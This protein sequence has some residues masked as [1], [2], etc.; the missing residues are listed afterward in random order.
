MKRYLKVCVLALA[1]LVTLS[2]GAAAQQRP[3]T[4]RVGNS[5]SNEPVIGATVAVVG[6]AI[7]A[8]TDARGE[9]TLAAPAGPV[10]LSVRAIGYKRRT[11]A[12]S[13]DQASVAIQVEADIF[14]LEAVVVTGQATAVEQK[15]LPQA[16]SVVTAQQ[17]EAVP[18]PTIESTLQGKIPG[19]LIQSNS[20][21]PG[22][23]AQI[24]LRG[25]STINGGVDPV[26][27]VDG[28]VVSNAAIGNN[29]NAITAAAAGG[30]ASNQ[31]NP[32]NRIADLNPAD[33]ERVEVLKGAS[34]AAIY[35]GAA[36]NGVL[37]ITTKRGAA[38][39]PR[40]HLT[41]RFGQYRVS[42][43]MKSRVFTDSADAAT[44]VGDSLAGV[45]CNLPGGA[46]P[47]Y[48][49]IGPLWKGHPLSW[50]TLASVTGG[51]DQTRYYISGLLKSDG[52]IAPGTGYDK[53]SIRANLDQTFGS[54]WL[55]SFSTSVIH[56]LA[57]RGISNNDNTGTSPYLVFP[58]TPGFVDLQSQNGVFPDNPF[59]RSN[60][61]QTYANL[62]NDE[63][64]WRALGAATLRFD[65]FNNE[66]QNLRFLVTGGLDHFIQE[67][68]IYSPP[69]LEFEPNDGQP[70]TVVLGKTSNVNLN[71]L[72]N[73]VHTYRTTGGMRATTALG[74][75]YVDRN[76]NFT[77]LVGRNLPPGQQNIDQAT[78]V[79]I[80]QT[81][82][83]TQDLGLFVQEELLTA[84][85]RLM[86]TFGVRADRSSRNGDVNKYYYY[87]KIAGSYRLTNLGGNSANEVKLR[88]AYGQT[89]NPPQFGN[90][91]TPN[92][93]G[94]IGGIFGSSAGAIAGD[95]G[96]KPERQAEIEA[97]LDATLAGGRLTVSLTGFNKS[98]TDLLL[99]Q[100]L[101]PSTGRTQRVFNGGELRNRGVEASAAY[102]VTQRADVSWIVKGTFFANRS[103]VVSLPVPAFQV[104]GFGTS[105]GAFEIRE[106]HSVT[107]IVG[108]PIDSLGLPTIVGDANPDFQMAFG[109][110]LEYHRWSVGFLFDWKKG[111]DVINLTE[112]LFDLFGNSI[113][114]TGAAQG[115]LN[116]FFAGRTQPYVQDASYLKLRE[117]AVSY[118]LPASATATLFGSVV[119]DARVTFAG[120]NL[121]RF[122]PFRGMDPEVS[123]FGNQAVARNIDVAPF[124]PSRSFFVAI[125][126][127][128]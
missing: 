85:E 48:D 31:D 93:T 63:D 111:G 109:S 16:V 128:F 1:W 99:A 84:D 35:G 119:R 28:L 71:L 36:S 9:F 26:L 53:Q 52:G 32:V 25:V 24:N 49:N 126:L 56:S 10:S 39:A 114:Q 74:V 76:F 22:G 33:I 92:A 4:G 89:G 62:R 105:L 23:G 120:R 57:A 91:F 110:D 101:A 72:T 44:F 5:V 116:D 100:T 38:G 68:D 60:P 43:Y 65:A 37:I 81:L 47:N 118:H 75:Q 19:A 59:E 67:N 108:T 55:L 54:K 61:L 50:E 3:V 45:Y 80:N 14:N 34:A 2:A 78:S 46:C 95:G 123:N 40:F 41:Q 21:A 127:D 82:Q 94:T 112:L 15:N 27:V 113:D 20:G 29:I 17:L 30:N 51:S 69:E 90:K 96:I 87:P 13:A 86:V 12:V 104:G 83:P 102:A 122:T 88:A 66:R 70:G 107:Q 103:K 64:V 125:D 124:P 18:T 73:V 42:N 79:T 97:G 6:T 58:L 115:R 8:V 7:A 77:N 11:V 98:I 106:G 121:L 117:L